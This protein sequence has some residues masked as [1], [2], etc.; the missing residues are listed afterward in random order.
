MLL[1]KILAFALHGKISCKNNKFEILA[2]RWRE[3]F[4]LSDR[5]YSVSDIQDCFEYIFK[6]HGGKTDN[7]LIKI[8]VNNTELNL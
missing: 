6:K 1:Y 2:P 4:E 5:S 8:C 3:E 7:P